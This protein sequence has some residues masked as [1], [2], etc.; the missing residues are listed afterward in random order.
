MRRLILL[1]VSGCLV[2]Q[3][4]AQL[5][6]AGVT[7][8]AGGTIVDVAKAAEWDDLNEWDNWAMM[9]KATGE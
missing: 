4:Q 1:F 5:H 3:I 8:G 7:V 9:V 2:V 6:S